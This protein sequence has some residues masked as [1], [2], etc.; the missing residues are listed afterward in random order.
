MDY[1]DCSALS[2]NGLIRRRSTYH[3]SGGTLHEMSLSPTFC[4]L[5][6]CVPVYRNIINALKLEDEIQGRVPEAF[7]C[8]NR[9]I[10]LTYWWPEQGFDHSNDVACFNLTKSNNKYIFNNQD[11]AVSYLEQ[12]DALCVEQEVAPKQLDKPNLHRPLELN[13]HSFPAFGHVKHFTEL[14][15]ESEH[16]LLRRCITKINHHNAQTSTVEHCLGNDWQRWISLLHQEV[17]K[18]NS[19][20][21]EKYKRGL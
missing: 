6:C 16:Q 11:L 8:L 2:E 13:F 3:I 17:K 9:L 18:S 12:V 10:G 20:D 7:E 1:M 15:L 5:L 4:M 14:V 21:E 19:D